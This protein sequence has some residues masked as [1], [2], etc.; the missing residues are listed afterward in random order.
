[1]HAFF[2]L[3][4]FQISNIDSHIV[5]VLTGFCDSFSRD[6][7]VCFSEGIPIILID[8]W[9]SSAPTDKCWN[10]AFKRSH[11]CSLK[12]LSQ[13]VTHNHRS[14]PLHKKFKRVRSINWNGNSRQTFEVN[15]RSVEMGYGC[16]D[17][18]TYLL[19]MKYKR[20]NLIKT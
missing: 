14:G 6:P 13:L 9:L 2:R 19:A 3:K 17:H 11:G 15:V 10:S 1:M 12:N 5:H 8:V 4:V 7:P 16:S 18:V 20:Q